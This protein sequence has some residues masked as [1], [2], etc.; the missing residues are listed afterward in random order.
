MMRWV[1]LLFTLMAACVAAMLLTVLLFLSVYPFSRLV[2]YLLFAR[3][4]RPIV[5]FALPGCLWVFFVATCRLPPS[6][7]LWLIGRVRDRLGLPPMTTGGVQGAFVGR[8]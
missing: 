4:L 6:V 3:P 7:F 5:K 8:C 1:G 2:R